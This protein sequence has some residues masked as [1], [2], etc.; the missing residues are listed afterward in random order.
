MTNC[1]YVNSSGKIHNK[2]SY[3]SGN[4]WAQ[5]PYKYY[6]QKVLGWREKDTKARF[7][8]GK[9]LE[10]SV[11]FHNENPGQDAVK[12][13]QRR[14]LANKDQGLSYTD[15]EKNW[16]NL[17]TVGSD[18]IRL[19]RAL[20]PT[21][22][23]PMGAKSAWQREYMKEAYP[24]DP[25]YGDIYDAGKLDII[26][27]VEPNHPMLQKM[28]WTEGEYRPV[29]IDIKTSAV[30]FPEQPGIAALDAQL[31]RYSW[32]SG[33]RDVALLWFRKCGTGFKRGYS[34]TI[35]EQVGDYK[36]GDEAVVAQVDGE[37][38]WIVK[39]DFML[40]E[41]DR[42]QG[43]KKNKND[44]DRTDQTDEAKQRAMNFLEQHGLKVHSGYLTRQKLQF[45]SGRVSERSAE[46]AGQIA[47]S[48]I[49]QIVNAWK[50]K[51]YPDG[52]GVR[53]PR[54]DRNDPYFRA[55]ILK[56][57]TFKKLNFT[58]RDEETLDDLF[59]EE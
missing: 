20:Q 1:L 43:T 51:Q 10:E 57:E 8:F 30:D 19:Y 47:A 3:S 27:Y 11:Q 38:I 55:F 25:N 23:I 35:L 59:E 36:P 29:I 42:V 58:K 34:V 17:N 31:R 6:L 49:V 15:V 21:L 18:M 9:S 32:L 44:E 48:Q 37:N 28:D 13:F 45:N 5:S 41:M 33:I 26:S 39:T 7:A 2:H 12:D 50:T 24:G 56:D 46:E 16:E 14:W 54:D 22:P 40:E 52:F 4:T 53:Y